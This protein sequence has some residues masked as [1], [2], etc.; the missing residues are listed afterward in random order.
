M[1][2]DRSA[3]AGLLDLSGRTAIVTGGARG[4]GAV[5]AQR[6]AQAGA[7]VLIH[8]RGHGANARQLVATVNSYGGRAAALRADLSDPQQV[9]GLMA[10]THSSF[11]RVDILVNNA[12]SYPSCELA[13]M[14]V[15]QWTAMFKAN[16]DTTFACTQAALPFMRAQGAGNIINIASMAALQPALG[17]AHYASAKAAILAFTRACAQEAGPSG[18]RVNALSPGLID[19]PGLAEGW[20]DG[21]ARW[22]AKAP[23][24]RVG[25]AADIADACL[26]LA[27]PAARWVSGHNLVVD[28]GMLSAPI[29]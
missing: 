5:I 3:I 17:H 18:I 27:S 8:H 10:C 7:A 4:I 11:G 23:L 25:T 29:F 1:S 22:N 19:R 16:V 28:G 13:D 20:P 9:K 26:F 2:W 6:L 15:E 12:G 21:V 24:G 14:T